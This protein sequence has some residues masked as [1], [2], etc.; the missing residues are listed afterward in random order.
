RRRAARRRRPP[1]AAGLQPRDGHQGRRAARALVLMTRTVVISGA[2]R[3]Q[4]LSHAEAFGREGANVVLLDVPQGL[5]TIPY[6]V[7]S[8][9]DLALAH[10]SVDACGDG[11]VLSY[12][13]DVR[14]A[15]AVRSVIDEAAGRLGGIDVTIANA[16]VFSFAATTWELSPEQWRECS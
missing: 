3:G 10:A 6:E 7:S 5:S 8:S 2:A 4:G 13:V 9:D 1:A 12:T 14:D 16:G 15:D 11:T